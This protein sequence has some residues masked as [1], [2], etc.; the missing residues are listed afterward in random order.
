MCHNKCRYNKGMIP[1]CE[2]ADLENTNNLYSSSS[3]YSNKD[4]SPRGSIIRE[5]D[6]ILA[7]QVNKRMTMAHQQFKQ[8]M[9]GINYHGDAQT[10]STSVLIGSQKQSFGKLNTPKPAPS[11][12]ASDDHESQKEIQLQIET[13]KKKIAS[14][15]HELHR[16]EKSLRSQSPSSSSSKNNNNSHLL[17]SASNVG[18]FQH[19][20]SA[21]SQSS[22]SSSSTQSSS[23]S[24]QPT[25]NAVV[26]NND[27]DDSKLSTTYKNIKANHIL[28]DK[29]WLIPP[30]KIQINKQL[31]EGASAQVFLGEY[32]GQDVAIKVMKNASNKQHLK[33]FESEFAVRFSNFLFYF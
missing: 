5:D 24:Q 8:V 3:Y 30:S 19:Q 25:N 21:T 15:T 2:C 12:S 31:G 7:E 4:R 26:E 28:N 20:N 18:H 17:S 11:S 1:A 13:T 9:K 10:S 22:S 33:D 16:L 32:R 23:S 6:E 27:V 29:D 14:L